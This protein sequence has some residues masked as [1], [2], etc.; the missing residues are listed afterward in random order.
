MQKGSKILDLNHSHLIIGAESEISRTAKIFTDETL[1]LAHGFSIAK[2]LLLIASRR[3][4]NSGNLTIHS[5]T[6][7]YF[8]T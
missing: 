4:V 2:S 1:L 6:R 7:K 8:S 5:M 3:T